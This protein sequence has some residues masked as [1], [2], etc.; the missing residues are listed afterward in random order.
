MHGGKGSGAPKHNRNAHKTGLHTRVV[1][2]RARELRSFVR[3]AKVLMAEI[4]AEHA[5]NQATLRSPAGAG[6]ADFSHSFQTVLDCS[7]ERW[8]S[9]PGRRERFAR[10]P[11]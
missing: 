3:S 6:N 4:D 11:G 2:E 5:D 9:D 10:G 7:G 8:I 1:K